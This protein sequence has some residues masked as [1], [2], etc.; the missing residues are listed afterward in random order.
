MEITLNEKQITILN[1]YGPNK[2]DFY[3]FKLLESTLPENVRL[4]ISVIDFLETKKPK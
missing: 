1:L 4:I 3:L 2:Y